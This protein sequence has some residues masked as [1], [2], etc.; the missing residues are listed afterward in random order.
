M[1]ISD[2][3][4]SLFTPVKFVLMSS[5]FVCHLMAPSTQNR[6]GRE[7]VIGQLLSLHFLS[8]A[9]WKCGSVKVNT[10]TAL[11][12]RYSIEN[13]HFWLTAAILTRLLVSALHLRTELYTFVPCT[14]PK[15]R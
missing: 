4:S 6:N 12:D 2:S 5:G 10:A 3:L 8:T 15:H 13:L 7:A 11:G 9:L 14:Q 1:K